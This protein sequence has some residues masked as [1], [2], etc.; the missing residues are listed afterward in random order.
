MTP[1]DPASG[2]PGDPGASRARA[3]R[4]TP[5]LGLAAVLLLVAASVAVAA[6]VA[7]G[8]GGGSDEGDEV[9]AGPATTTELTDP[10]TRPE[11]LRA[12]GIV[13]FDPDLPL[14]LSGVSGV[15]AQEEARATQ[16]VVDVGEA[17]PAYASIDDALA[18]GYVSIGDGFTGNEH[19]IDW[20]SVVDDETLVVDR[21][22]GLLYDVAPDG[23][24]TLAAFLFLLA[25]GRALAD[26]PE[27][28]GTLTPWTLWGDLCLAEGPP[29]EIVGTTD[30]AATCPPGSDLQ[31][32]SP[33]LRVWVARHPCGPFSDLEG[34]GDETM[35]ELLGA[36]LHDH[37]L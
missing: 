32:S 5:F 22:E 14:D 25:P 8:D 37:G 23:T 36:C 31:A 2:P 28:G 33:A 11:Q 21:P 24:R 16:L 20:P 1:A 26:A 30:A 27:V 29:P 34:V 19:L 7:R 6:V 15:T 9:T 12:A 17:A 3:R 13:A 4:L 10:R 35:G 18:A